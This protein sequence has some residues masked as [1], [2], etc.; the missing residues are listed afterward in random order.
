[1]I[2]RTAVSFDVVY[3]LGPSP[4]D[5]AAKAAGIPSLDGVDQLVYQALDQFRLMTGRECDPAPLL[6]V[7][8]AELAERDARLSGA[9]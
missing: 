9:R 3:G 7:C 8:R 5:L 4:L 2:G 1:M 6:Q